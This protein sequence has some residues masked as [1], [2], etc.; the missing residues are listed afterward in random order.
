MRS[1]WNWQQLPNPSSTTIYAA[2]LPQPWPVRVRPA[3]SL[4]QRAATHALHRPRLPRRHNPLHGLSPPLVRNLH[5][6]PPGR[7]LRPTHPKGHRSTAPQ[8]G[9]PILGVSFQFPCRR[10]RHPRHRRPPRRRLPPSHP[11]RCSR[12]RLPSSNPRRCRRRRRLPSSNPLRCRCRHRP[13]PQPPPLPTRSQRTCGMPSALPP[14]RLVLPLVRDSSHI[15]A[16][17]SRSP[18]RRPTSRP[19]P[20]PLILSILRPPRP[21]TLPSSASASD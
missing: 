9:A 1:R 10:R 3:L 20:H 16:A 14:L 13:P 7:R 2:Q 18:S 4:R 12:R 6:S 19:T 15:A 17:P 5:P 21:P 11:P 8:D